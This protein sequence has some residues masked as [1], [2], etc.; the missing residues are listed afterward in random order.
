[1]VATE[2]V[3][4][5]SHHLASH[6]WPSLCSPDQ[7]GLDRKCDVLH[8]R[9]VYFCMEKGEGCKDMFAGLCLSVNQATIRLWIC[10]CTPV[11]TWDVKAKKGAIC[12]QRRGH[13]KLWKKKK[14]ILFASLSGLL[15]GQAMPNRHCSHCRVVL[16]GWTSC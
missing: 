10:V 16:P 12:L 14:K 9:E 15:N 11:L 1:M 6:Q 13:R 4:R 2:H 8:F 3:R 5:D 7:T